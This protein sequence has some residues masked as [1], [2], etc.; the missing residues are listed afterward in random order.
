MAT[1]LHESGAHQVPPD[2]LR[3]EEAMQ[4]DTHA[5]V[6]TLTAAGA[7]EPLAGAVVA[8]VW[9]AIAGHVHDLSTRGDLADL[10]AHVDDG[11]A[12][13]R[14]DVGHDL[15]TLRADVGR[16]LATLELRL[17]KWII[18]TV[19]AGAGVTVAALRLLG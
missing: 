13:L 15:A 5:A 7:P 1:G 11:L 3:Y 8:V 2:L 19:V 18:G 16:D 12:T 9:E 6:K 4:F 14:A 10:R 17:V